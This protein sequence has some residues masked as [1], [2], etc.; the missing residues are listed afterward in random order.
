[1]SRPIGALL[2][3]ALAALLAMPA[4]AA[5]NVPSPAS[6]TNPTLTWGGH[7]AGNA[8]L[9][10]SYSAAAPQDA[11]TA[12]ISGPAMT[13]S[14]GAYYKITSCVSVHRY[15]DL[16]ARNCA[17]KL[18]DGRGKSGT[19]TSAAPVVSQTVKRPPVGSTG[20]KAWAWG[21]VQLSM[22]GSDGK[23]ITT[24]IATSWPSA[25][26]SRGGIG[27]AAQGA[28]SGSLPATQGVSLDD[29][30]ERSGPSTFQTGGI[31]NGL[32][33]S[34]C[35]DAKL[36]ASPR[37]ADLSTTALGTMPAYYEVG[38]PTGAFAGRSPKGV[39]LL[40]HGGYWFVTGQGAAE[41]MR[42]DATRWRNRGWLTVNLSYRA[43]GQ[44][45]NDVIAFYDRVSAR[46]PTTPICALGSSAGGHLAM[47]LAG[48]KPQLACAIGQGTPTDL[49]KAKDEAAYNSATGTFSLIKAG[50]TEYNMGVAAFGLENLS[51]YS[52][53]SWAPQVRARLLLVSAGDD[54]II[55]YQQTVDMRDAVLASRPSAYVDTARFER[56]NQPWVHG[57][58]SPAG[59]ADYHAREL[60]LVT[61]IVAP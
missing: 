39:M 19:L 52:P 13:V 10:V 22:M 35:A 16:P 29:S 36:P 9:A 59:L 53:T 42:G 5:A 46:Y 56:G 18:L 58:I 32:A 15:G 31:N 61:G 43:C 38:Q 23:W 2:A 12:T 34:I 21:V 30:I 14:A 27:I 33:D 17:D 4:A 20:A 6:I 49:R 11:A 57:T 41:A 25:G 3:F 54:W 44:S 51:W 1:M 60:R 26:L 8:T 55:P 48:V 50:R 47:M 45:L 28:T 40:I 7:N 24:P 37:P